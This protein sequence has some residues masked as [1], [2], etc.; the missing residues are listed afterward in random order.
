TRPAQINASPTA[1][2]PSTRNRR[3]IWI[4]DRIPVGDTISIARS[5]AEPP[6]ANAPPSER[7]Y[8]RLRR[9]ASPTRHIVALKT[10]SFHIVPKIWTVS[11]PPKFLAL[12]NEEN[13][14]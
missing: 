13:S 5:R 10:A 6:S 3:Y 9:A 12:S 7:K 8:F 14:P 2:I 4:E 1:S 11:P